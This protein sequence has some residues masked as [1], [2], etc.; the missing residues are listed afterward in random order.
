MDEA[1]SV[2]NP[3]EIPQTEDVV[4]FGRSRQQDPKGRS[5]DFKRSGYDGSH[6]AENIRRESSF[7]YNFFK[8]IFKDQL[9]I[10]NKIGEVIRLNELL[11]WC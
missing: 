7:L 4:R 11:R 1:T 10:L 5:I 3:G 9:R 8:K 2:N 6:Q